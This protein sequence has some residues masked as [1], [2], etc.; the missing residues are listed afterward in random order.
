M[1]S[2]NCW[3]GGKPSTA[4]ASN[5]VG[6]GA[7]VGRAVKL[8]ERQRG[9]Q[10]EAARLLMLGDGDRGLQ[11]LLGRRGIRGVPLQ[12]NLGADAVHLRFIPALGALQLGERVI[13]A[14]EPGLYVI[15][16]CFA[17]GQGRF[18]TG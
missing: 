9:A 8:R 15:G 1:S 14:L 2:G 3:V 12:Q 4:G 13:Q 17:I 6:V 7:A 10:F 18:E 16:T 5:R 11:G